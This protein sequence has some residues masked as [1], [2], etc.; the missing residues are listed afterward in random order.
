MVQR[1]LHSN[2]VRNKYRSHLEEEKTIMLEAKK[3]IVS[4]KSFF[5]LFEEALLA[6]PAVDERVVSMYF[7]VV[8]VKIINAQ[9]GT[10]FKVFHELFIGYYLNKINV[11][12]RKILQVQTKNKH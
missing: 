3:N 5:S 1:T 6:L 7:K 9:A 8:V 4:S 11:E 10:V 2:Q 12:F